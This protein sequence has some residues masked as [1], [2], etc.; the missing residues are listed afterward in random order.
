MKDNNIIDNRQVDY[1]YID[2]CNMLQ[3]SENT[4]KEWCSFFQDLIKVRT[5][6][7]VRKF[8]Q[9]DLEKLAFIKY[10]VI[11]K[12]MT[13][14]EAHNYCMNNG[15]KDANCN[16]VVL[17]NKEFMQEFA[18]IIITEMNNQFAQLKESLDNNTKALKDLKDNSNVLSDDFVNISE[19]I[20]NNLRLDVQNYIDNASNA[21]REFA[22]DYNKERNEERNEDYLELKS[23]IKETKEIC[24]NVIEEVQYLKR[25]ERIK[26]QSLFYK[27]FHK[28]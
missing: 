14:V 23:D 8:N 10:L 16:I 1:N 6:K 25:R 28:K 11:D 2:V 7:M 26:Q 21:F 22:I 4:I 20:S 13:I 24:N 15:F 18:K 3:V 5:H 19:G 9:D 17:N 12:K 27:I